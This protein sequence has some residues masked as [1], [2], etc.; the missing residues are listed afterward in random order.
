MDLINAFGARLVGVREITNEIF[1]PTS[2]LTSFQ[3][4]H[5]KLHQ[6]ARIV[7]RR[8]PC[9]GGCKAAKVIYGHFKR[10][11]LSVL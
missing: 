1:A 11:L 2:N 3:S 5:S 4:P 8:F 10:P 6:P 9:Q 7:L